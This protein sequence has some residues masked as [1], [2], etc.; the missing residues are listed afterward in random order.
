ML[1]IAVEFF[2]YS[3]V[4][5][6]SDVEAAYRQITAA[7]EQARPFIVAMWDPVKGCVAY[8]IAVSQLF[9]SGSAPL[10]FL[11]FPAW[12]VYALGMTFGLLSHHRVD[13]ILFVE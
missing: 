11:R 3:L 5:S 9:G 10:N 4:G 2:D 13:N 8:S 1:R 7:T 6:T 12:Y